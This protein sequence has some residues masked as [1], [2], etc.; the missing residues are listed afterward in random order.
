MP[1]EIASAAAP[2]STSTRALEAEYYVRPEWWAYECKEVF[3]SSWQWV[4]TA[5]E[6]AA[7]GT[8]LAVDGAPIPL[9]VL[10]DQDG[11]LRAWHNVCRHRAG[12]LLCGRAQGLKRLRCRYH[13]WTYTLD[14]CLR[15]APELR[16][17][18]DFDF[19][20]FGLRPAAV[21]TWRGMVFVHADPDADFAPLVAGLDERLGALDL[22]AFVHQQRVGYTLD[23][24]WKVYVDNYLEGYHVPHIHPSLNAVLDY[25]R[26]R[27]EVY[28]QSSLQAS[29]LD[30]TPGVYAAGE[31]LYVHLWPNT[32]LNVLP[33]R[34]QTNRVLPLSPER[35]RV[36]FDYYYPGSLSAAARAARFEADHR[37]ADP[38]QA[39]DA[40]I[41]VYV[42]RALASGSYRPGPLHPE[43]E[44]AVLAFQHRL[45]VCYARA[46][47]PG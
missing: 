42:Q 24:N 25:R 21:R 8:A 44:R 26:Y 20:D 15:V 39:E 40:E 45:S 34:L 18:V 13:G 30:E 31:A 3:G 2:P 41:C 5:A 28:P 7:P 35:C 6:L 22:S 17:G 43:R 37:F 38:I 19:A 27:T 4:G 1:S 23:C 47:A 11:A 14:G 16:D 36:E 33:E 9:L 46:R 12:P 10:R 32:M 29:P